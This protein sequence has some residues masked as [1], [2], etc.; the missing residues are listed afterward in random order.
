MKPL[1]KQ[2]LKFY[3]KIITKIVLLIHRPRIIAIAGSTN[4]SFV[5]DAIKNILIKKGVA[6][7]ANPKNFNTE[8]GLPLAI[9]SIESGYGSYLAW[10]PVMFDAFKAIF[11]R[12]FPKVLVLELGVSRR[13]DMKYLLSLIRPEI[14]IVT[15]ITQRYIEAFSG[16]D[17]MLEE[18]E[19]LVKHVEKSGFVILNHDNLQVRGLAEGSKA[20]VIY[21]GKTADGERGY[22]IEKIKKTEKG[23]RIE[24]AHGGLKEELEIPRF[25]EHHAY[26]AAGGMIIEKEIR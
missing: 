21:F 20:K 10:P 5:R 24:I 16:L 4:K 19:Y 2:F 14:T 26:A 1:C 9:L 8:I 15:N 6:V 17:R 25:G 12:N 7:R 3:L 11:K 13:G 18:Y 22:E 23:Q